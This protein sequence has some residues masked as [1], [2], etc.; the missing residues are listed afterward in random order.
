MVAGYQKWQRKELDAALREGRSSS[1]S[2]AEADTQQRE[3]PRCPVIAGRPFEPLD[4]VVAADPYPWLHL[5]HREA[6][7]FYMPE[8][9]AWCVT[10]YGDVLEVIRDTTS[11]SSRKVIQ[12]A[13]LAPEFEEA[14]AD[15][16]PD[17]V[18][19][20]TDPPEH[21][22]LRKLAQK[23]FTPKLI[24][25]REEEV[26]AL[27]DA[28]IDAFIDRGRCDLV[29][30]F[31]EHLPVQAIT[32]LVGAPLERTADFARWAYDRI[33][34]LAGGRQLSREERLE[35]SR[36]AVEFNEWLR[37]F[38]EERRAHPQDDLASGLVHAQT[39]DGDPA[40]STG[41]V[42]TMIGTFLSAGTSTTA[43]FIPML[44]RELL[45]RPEAWTRVRGDREL[46]ARAVEEGLR[47]RTSVHGV[48]RTTTCDVVLGGVEIPAGSDLYVHYAAAQRDESVFSD[49]DAFDVDR[50]NVKQHFAFGK[51]AHI[52]LGAPLARLETRVALECFAERMPNMRLVPDQ[53]EEWLPHMLTP[54]LASLQIEW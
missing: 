32:R 1:G 7:V 8:H 54:G 29:G 35:L 3:A 11:Y 4:P 16:P 47:H 33:A 27:A 22:R 17:R 30:E 14:F 25:S 21:T 31:A 18:L 46:I 26:R 10:S 15:G 42:V 9:D 50:E 13:Q 38:V 6:P 40:L 41:E 19:V 37:E 43:H 23:G 12:F 44:V 28:L 51:W 24:A 52:C 20:T 48:T 39:D 2:M 36:R 45:L 53:P 49:P 5:A 34:M